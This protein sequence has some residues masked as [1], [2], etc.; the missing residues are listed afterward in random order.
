[1]VFEGDFEGFLEVT[2][3]RKHFLWFVTELSDKPIALSLWKYQDCFTDHSLIEPELLREI[4]FHENTHER[5]QFLV[6]LVH[7][8]L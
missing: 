3:S 6:L 7:T 4:V 1:M 2:P 8:S 5:T